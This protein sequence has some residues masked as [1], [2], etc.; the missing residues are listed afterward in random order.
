MLAQRRQ[1]L[2]RSHPNTG[3]G[4]NTC[5]SWLKLINDCSFSIDRGHDKLLG[6]S[7]RASIL[8]FISSLVSGTAFSM[9]SKAFRHS[10]SPNLIN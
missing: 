9:Q 7:G 4:K 6:Y 2:H 5:S 8:T 10:V 3:R 1:Q